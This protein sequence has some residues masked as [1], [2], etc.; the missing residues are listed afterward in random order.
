MV[1]T[2]CEKHTVHKVP[3]KQ[4]AVS[5]QEASRQTLL[6]QGHQI[7]PAQTNVFISEVSQ[8]LLC[9]RHI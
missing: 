9:F 5:E 1:F 2:K 7:T 8:L 3:V 6:E 4:V